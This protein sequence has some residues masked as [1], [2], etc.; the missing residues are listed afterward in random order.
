MRPA[1]VEPRE[2]V[3]EIIFADFA[4]DFGMRADVFFFGKRIVNESVG[5][6]PEPPDFAGFERSLIEF[7]LV[8]DESLAQI[9]IVVHRE[10]VIVKY[11]ADFG[12]AVKVRLNSL[13]VKPMVGAFGV[14]IRY[15]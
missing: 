2:I 3:D 11:T 9:Q 5:D 10:T 8:F 12:V 7:F 15:E 13:F 14:G 4:E 6:S 1:P